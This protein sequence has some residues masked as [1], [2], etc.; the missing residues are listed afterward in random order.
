MRVAFLDCF[1]GISGDMCLGALVGAGLD[2]ELLND[3]L[4]KLPVEGY[5]LRYEKTAYSGIFAVNLFVDVD[6]SAHGHRHLRDIEGIIGKSTLPEEVK[7][8]S[9]AVFRCIALA[10]ANVH[11]TTVDHVH[12]HEVGAIDTII[13]VVGTVLGLYVL[14]VK[15]VLVSPLPMGKGSVQC[16]HGII[17]LPAP[18]TLEI[19]CQKPIPVYG[20]DIDMELVTPTGAALAATLG[21]YYGQMPLMTISR[22]G[23]GAGKKKMLHP[24]MLR[25][26]TGDLIELS[27]GAGDTCLQHSATHHAGHSQPEVSGEAIMQALHKQGPDITDINNG[28]RKADFVFHKKC[29]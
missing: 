7:E 26:V 16:M 14:G 21:E 1:S 9:K 23:Y 25:I 6:D 8:K 17:P 10:E 5:R 19:L 22:V 18:A 13:D 20:T 12:F 27:G 28:S 11:N 3:E 4:S 15:K 24:N 29:C 2:F